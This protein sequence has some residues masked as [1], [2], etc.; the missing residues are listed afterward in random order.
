[1]IECVERCARSWNPTDRSGSLT[2]SQWNLRIIKV[3]GA[4]TPWDYWLQSWALPGF[5]VFDFSALSAPEFY[6]LFTRVHPCQIS[7]VDRGCDT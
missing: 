1:M 4:V 3:I 5:S 2:T 7:D 6:C